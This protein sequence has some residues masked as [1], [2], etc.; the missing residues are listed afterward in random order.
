M[1][2]RPKEKAQKEKR[3]KGKRQKGG[4]SKGKEDGRKDRKGESASANEEEKDG[5]SGIRDTSYSIREQQWA[6]ISRRS[7][8]RY[9][10][11]RNSRYD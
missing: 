2:K 10:E 5:K 11:Y 4:D 3:P 7:G 9:Q 1:E 6:P 8:R